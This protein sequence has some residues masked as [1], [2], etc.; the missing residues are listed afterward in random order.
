MRKARELKS[1][2][3]LRK[4][5][6]PKFYK[7][8]GVEAM[9]AYV[10]QHYFRKDSTKHWHYDYNGLRYWFWERVNYPHPKGCWLVRLPQFPWG[11]LCTIGWLTCTLPSRFAMHRQEAY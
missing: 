9:L 5:K 3:D 4:F 7:D 1:F 11:G 8:L 2:K 6:I 10:R